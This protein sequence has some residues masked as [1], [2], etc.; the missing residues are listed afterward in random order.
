MKRLFCG[1]VALSLSGC[2]SG[3]TSPPSN[4]PAEIPITSKSP[5]A[6]D[7]FK[8]GR[9]LLEN[10]RSTEAA[11]EFNQAVTLDPEFVSARAYLGIATPGAEG[12]K[13]LEQATSSAAALPETERL[14]IEATLANRRSE[15]GKSVTLYTELTHKAPSDWRA[16]AA[17]GGELAIQQKHA[18]AI[19]ALRK[20]TTLNPKAG[21]AYNS[22]G[23]ESLRQGDTTGAIEAFKQY[24]SL[25]PTEPN[26]QDSYGEALLG[27]GRFDEAA[28][29]YEKA[30]A[31]S[32]RFWNAWEGKAYV[33][34]FT[35]D[36]AAGDEALG[37]ARSA[38]SRPSDR[39]AVDEVAGFAALARGNAADALKRFDAAAKEPD[40]QP[41]QMAQM[42]VDR[43]LVYVETA[44]Y[45][46]ALAQASDALQL[47]DSGKLPPG[48]ATNIRNLALVSRIAAEAK[49]GQAD[50]A[51]KTVDAF[52]GEASSHP[53]NPTVQS[54][55]HFALGMLSV[56]KKD[57]AGA[58]A[59]FA[60]CSSLDSY[61]RWQQVLAA[62]KAGDKAASQ[63]ARDQLLRV[64]QRDPVYLYVRSKAAPV[65]A[66]R[67]SN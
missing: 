2:S 62:E 31:L 25:E 32:P 11:E 57:L 22:L 42:S 17:L 4:Q 14:F 21:T 27:A 49:M 55:L 34:F 5:E 3:T 10:V 45:K 33:K 29:A 20:A 19:E 60:Q 59:H 44:R 53:D 24:A 43:A 47:V 63:A 56:A 35:G 1:I 64:Y 48:G 9:T 40:T 30:A 66:P 38:T 65:K 50:A 37:K 67:Q 61:C 8:K 16:Y 46:E 12:L 58:A 7:H 36:W 39:N 41:V 26:P 51:Q 18:E 54:S 52:Q 23:Y 15:L 13:Q 28:A 6:I